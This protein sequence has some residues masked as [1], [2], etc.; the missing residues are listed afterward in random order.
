MGS[1][2]INHRSRLCYS[3]AARCPIASCKYVPR[4]QSVVPP[5]AAPSSYQHRTKG[6]RISNVFSTFAQHH[7]LH[8]E[9]RPP[10]SRRQKLSPPEPLDHPLGLH[11]NMHTHTSRKPARLGFTKG[12]ATQTRRKGI[13]TMRGTNARPC[14]TPG[15]SDAKSTY[16][17]GSGWPRCC[18][19]WPGLS[20]TFS[21]PHFPS[22]C[23]RLLMTRRTGPRRARL[24]QA[25]R[26]W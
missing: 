6:E 1:S 4:G 8:L 19:R 18:T 16:A 9:V 15:C 2:P 13:E 14:S 21:S 3:D 5:H 25:C 11:S 23:R 24:S 7:Q 22:I 10:N 26:R 12:N 20:H 17:D